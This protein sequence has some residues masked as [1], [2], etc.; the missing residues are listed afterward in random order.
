MKHTEETKRKISETKKGHPVSKE[1][2]RKTSETL[3]GFKPSKEARIRMSVGRK[4]MV[5]TEEHRKNMSEAQKGRVFSR[6]TRRNMSEG[7]KGIVFTE[8][9][10]RKLSE[11]H[12][13]EKGSN[14]QGGISFLPYPIGWTES[15]RE[16]IRE[17]DNYVCQ[18][19]GIH[20]DE[21]ERNLH[22]HHIDYDKDN[23]DPKNLISLCQS[24]HMKTNYDRDKWYEY[25]N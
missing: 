3:K 23:L 1:T 15:L 10:K 18:L 8:E 22:I 16:S 7:H 14:W 12:K 5:F 13:G 19:C 2:R 24:C 4:G 11:A 21:L 17:R 9:H 25:F 6:E 20:Q